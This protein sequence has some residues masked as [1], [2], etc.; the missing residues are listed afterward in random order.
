MNNQN[1]EVTVFYGE[2][3]VHPHERRAV[4]VVRREL[5]RRNISATLLVNFTVV[6]NGG[7]QI[8]LV[9]I[10]DQRYL[11]VELKC[12]DSTLPLIAT[13]NGPWR[14]QLPD[15]T[16]REL[17]RNFYDQAVQQTYGLSDT[18]ADLAAKGLVPGPQRDK[19]FH[20]IDTVVCVDPRIPAGS[21][22]PRHRNVSVVGLDALIDRVVRPGPGLAHW[23]RQH[24]GEVI[25][26]LGLYAEGDDDPAALRRRADAAAI[27]DYRRRFREFTAAGL[28]P[29]IPATARID[30]QPATVDAASLAEE[31]TPERRRLLLG[32]ASGDGKSHLAKHAALALTDNGHIVLWLAADD[33]DKD[34]L[35][36]SLA[37]AVGPFST[38]KVDA[39][40]AKAAEAGIGITVI[41]DA[42]EKCPHREELV[43]QLH[44]LQ[45]HHPASVL[46]TTADAAGTE[47]LAA[48]THVELASPTG[49]ERARLATTYGT[50]DGVA[51]SGEY[52]TRYD[53]TLA[54]QVITELPPGATTTD[55][56]DSYIRRRTQNETVRAG[57]RCLAAVMDDGVRTALP[58]SEAMLALR[59]CAPVA[60][61]PSAIDDTLASQL[62]TIHQ[63]RLRF[64]HERLGRFLAAEH[65]V[66]SA[67]DGTALAQMLTLPAHHDLQHYAL[68]LESDPGRRYD[69]IRHLANWQ[70]LS[71]AAHGK[72]GEDTAKQA[73][74]DI[75]EL[76]IQAVAVA[77]EA[78]FSVAD[79]HEV[80]MFGTW[81][82]ARQWTPAERA[83][84]AAAGHCVRGGLFLHEIG[85]LMD[86][87][88]IA[89][90]AAI[91]ALREAGNPDAVSTVI[92]STFAPFTPGADAAPAS[93]V[94]HAAHM[95]R[96]F[97]DDRTVT[98]TATPMWKPN[99]HCYGRLYMAALLSHPV[100]H[101]E[102]AENL[103][104]LVETGL[105]VG[106]YHLR[107]ELLEAAMYGCTSLEGQARQRMIEVLHGYTPA[108]GDW[109]TS[110]MLIEALAGYDEITPM[111]TLESIGESIAEA[112]RDENDPDHQT[113]ARSAVSN[114]FLS[115]TAAAPGRSRRTPRNTAPSR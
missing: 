17:D 86:G 36:R 2:Q 85:A 84:L 97:S 15:G 78:T 61:T 8:D 38:E 56:L 10:T 80:T 83:M 35:R 51:E 13:P 66:L 95:A 63:G 94:S 44:A 79:D 7:R 20:H 47:P 91:A 49:E 28:A 93:I 103:P 29:L 69:A 76:L 26:R 98:P 33:Y 81:S 19:F 74:A 9:I 42:L 12:L 65:L 64:D 22:T 92:G 106:G 60:T 25:R 37:R 14:Q 18:L 82:S 52:L 50:S 89:M 87:T 16:V 109:G 57:L 48:T 114:M 101:P 32:G 23:T 34:R 110:T 102:D 68:L 90:R 31:L 107:L 39:L 77:Q 40:L 58:I 46:V 55:V 3:P 53:I 59:R 43:K 71:D 11:I 108:T 112:L 100:R 54:A 4:N 21:T 115:P 6:A 41:I 113:V 72:F 30:G 96:V 70:L 73:R 88:D 62:V 99:P 105:S 27:Q 111:N 24:W 67:T 104:D 45:Q 5:A 1:T 75:T